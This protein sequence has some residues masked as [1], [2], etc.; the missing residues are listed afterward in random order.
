M[1]TLIDGV[2][3]SIQWEEEKNL[4]EVRKSLSAWLEGQGFQLS[5]LLINGKALEN[6]GLPLDAMETLEA[7]TVSLQDKPLQ[8]LGL[9]RDFF[10]LVSEAL[11]HGNEPVIQDLQNDYRFLSA[12]LFPLLN[13]VRSRIDADLRPF[14]TWDDPREM[15]FAS[16]NLT[17]TLDRWAEEIQEPQ[18]HFDQA[19][20]RVSDLLPPLKNIAVQFQKG[21]D[22]QAFNLLLEALSLVEDL[23]RLAGLLPQGWE[24]QFSQSF[25]WTQLSGELFSFL[26]EIQGAMEQK[27]LVLLADLLEYE[28]CPRL[29]ILL[30]RDQPLP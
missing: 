2:E 15:A 25:V 27:D 29:E 26:E 6:E 22:R 19:L 9:L 14:E 10:H 23:H 7:E 5:S 17:R 8:T 13:P 11:R 21:Q 16:Q 28:I 1:K 3:V 24:A 12:H 30:D 20:Q 4:G 18:K